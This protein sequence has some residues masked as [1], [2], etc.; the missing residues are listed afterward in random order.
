MDIDR[1]ECSA[2]TSFC[3]IGF[4]CAKCYEFISLFC[5]FR[6]LLCGDLGKGEVVIAGD[7]VKD[8]L[9]ATYGH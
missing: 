6:L 9:E 4:Q 7:Y 3:C 5:S 2:F 8:K 1:G